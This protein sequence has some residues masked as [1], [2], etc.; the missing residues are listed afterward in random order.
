MEIVIKKNEKNH[1]EFTLKGERHTFPNLL[2]SKLLEDTSVTFVSSILKHPMDKDTQFVI[3]TKPNKAAKKALTDA[4]DAI[5][6]ELKKFR[7]EVK[8]TLK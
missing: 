8:K 7:S 4:S 1:I 3:K 2:K 6:S 5:D